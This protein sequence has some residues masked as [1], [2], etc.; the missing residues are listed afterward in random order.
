[1]LDPLDWVGGRAVRRARHPERPATDEFDSDTLNPPLVLGAS[2]P[3][4]RSWEREPADP[5]TYGD[6]GGTF[7]L[8]TQAG[9][10]T[11]DDDGASVLTQAAPASSYAVQT[12]L[13]LDVPPS[14]AGYDYVLGGLVIYGSD[15]R[16]L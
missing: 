12:V 8:A 9:G 3:T 13:R 15:D 10:V 11:G 5:A 6:S 4:R 1:M 14:G 7:H 2:P 16:F